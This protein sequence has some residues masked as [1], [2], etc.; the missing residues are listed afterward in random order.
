MAVARLTISAT[1]EYTVERREI[2]RTGTGDHR[3]LRVRPITANLST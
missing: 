2:R 3:V 1:I